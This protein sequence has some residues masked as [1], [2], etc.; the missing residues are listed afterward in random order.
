LTSNESESA[1]LNFSQLE[2]DDLRDR[3]GRIR[4]PDEVA[5]AGWSD[6]GGDLSI[7]D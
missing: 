7:E 2:F 3:L 6:S 5:G 1:F 4:W